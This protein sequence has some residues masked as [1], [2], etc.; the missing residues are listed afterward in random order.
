MAVLDSHTSAR[1]QRH[2]APGCEESRQR[3]AVQA[4]YKAGR[5][6]QREIQDAFLSIWVLKIWT[7]PR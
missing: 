6:P 7:A 3:A 5:E 1:L 4:V 2:L